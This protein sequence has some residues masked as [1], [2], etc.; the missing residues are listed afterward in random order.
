MDMQLYN[1]F[2]DF[3]REKNWLFNPRNQPQAKRVI[4]VMVEI[5]WYL[6]P[7]WTKFS[8]RSCKLPA[9]FSKFQK[10]KKLDVQKKAKPIVSS[11]F[12]HVAILL[13]PTRFIPYTF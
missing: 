7:H 13:C 9:I 6:D 3:L 11:R 10:Y 8:E 5:L 12:L 1:D 4:K 2:I